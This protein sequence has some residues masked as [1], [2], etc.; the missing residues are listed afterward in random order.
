VAAPFGDTETAGLGGIGLGSGG[1]S[2]M[3]IGAAPLEIGSPLPGI[4]GDEAIPNPHDLGEPA[5]LA[6]L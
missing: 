6:R 4:S 1:L 5:Y 2:E 3:Q